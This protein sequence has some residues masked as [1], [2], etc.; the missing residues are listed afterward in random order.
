[1]DSPDLLELLGIDPA[2]LEP[3]P[4]N[5]S[6]RSS[7]HLTEQHACLRCGRPATLAGVIDVPTL[8]SRWIDRCGPCFVATSSRPS[9]TAAP[10]E[11]TLAVLRDA[12]L[13]AGVRLHVMI[14]D[15]RRE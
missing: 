5:A 2:D 3:A 13:E 8:G 11:D 6:Y 4:P 1:M 10:L 9:G 14:E 15:D 7:S 12:A